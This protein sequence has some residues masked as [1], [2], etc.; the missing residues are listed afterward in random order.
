MLVQESLKS[1]LAKVEE[2]NEEALK[3]AA[4]DRPYKNEAED[5]LHIISWGQEVLK[6]RTYDPIVV[7]GISIGSFRYVRAA[8]EYWISLRKA[9]IDHKT[10]AK[11]P[12]KMIE[13]LSAIIKPVRDLADSIE[14]P[15]SDILAELRLD[16]TLP[17]AGNDEW[18]VFICH[19]SEDKRAFVNSFA[20]ALRD[21][22]LRVW[23]D[24]FILTLG[25]SLRRSIDRGLAHSRYGIVILSPYFFAKNWPQRELDGLVSLE[26]NGRK[27]ILPI[28]HNI[29]AAGVRTYSPTLADRISLSTMESMTKLVSSVLAVVRQLAK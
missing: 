8:L 6:D 1:L 25:D 10:A 24:E 2:W 5:I 18:D 15:P 29:D 27:V 14:Y 19:A 13:A 17:D 4:V 3:H 26:N 20:R 21:A 28:R 22:G 23:Y 12:T 9:E 11:W 7:Q 16:S